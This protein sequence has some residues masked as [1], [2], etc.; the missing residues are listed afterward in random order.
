[1]EFDVWPA[2]LLAA[3]AIREP[4]VPLWVMELTA[5]VLLHVWLFCFGA[6]VGSF[7][8]VVVYRLPRGLSLA[9]PG[10]QCPRCGHAIRLWDNIPILSWLVLRGRCRDCGGRISSRYFWIE[11]LVAGMFLA[12]AFWERLSFVGT[13]GFETRPPLTPY[14]I[15]PFWSR[16]VT[17]VALLAT[18]LG[19]VLILGDHFATPARLFVPAIVLG[20]VLPLIWPEIRSVPAWSYGKLP[21]WQ[22]GLI[23]GVAAILI[24]LVPALAGSLWRLSANREWPSFAPLSWTAALAVVLGWQRTLLWMAPVLILYLL[25]AGAIRAWR[26][27]TTEPPTTD[28]PTSDSPPQE[29]PAP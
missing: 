14:D 4:R 13:W 23:D 28:P 18:L 25:A 16:Y 27:P 6:C 2:V 9:H 3:P 22:A 24:G 29:P 7:L 26:P 19:G 1:M 20:L 11:L 8:N 12:V 5:S 10:S 15:W 17:H 21:A